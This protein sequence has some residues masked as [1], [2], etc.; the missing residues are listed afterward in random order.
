M[1][2]SMTIVMALM[3]AS[4]AFAR[5]APHHRFKHSISSKHQPVSKADAGRVL[6]HPDDVALDRKIGSICRG[7]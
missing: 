7:C 1:I 2:A 3:T 5:K 6:R 4:S